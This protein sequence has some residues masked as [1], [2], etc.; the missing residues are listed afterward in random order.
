MFEAL[1]ALLAVL[2]CAGLL[3]GAALYML[4]LGVRFS[5][6][7]LVLAVFVVGLTPALGGMAAEEA[8]AGMRA[9]LWAGALALTALAALYQIYGIYWASIKP[10]PSP[11]GQ[12]WQRFGPS[13]ALTF[14]GGLGF[15]WIVLDRSR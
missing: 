3:G 14:A 10:A 11:Q 1:A 8:P 2:L 15:V 13:L 12:F 6:G 5:L 7:D 9:R 4:R